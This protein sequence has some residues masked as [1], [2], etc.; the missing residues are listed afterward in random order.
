[1]QNPNPVPIVVLISGNGSN[2]Q[3]IIDAIQTQLLPIRIKAVISSD[4]N[5]YGL[6]RAELA[7]IPQHALSPADYSDRQS[8][9]QALATCIDNYNTELI[10]LAG[11]MR[12]LGNEFLTTFK[13][14]ILN[15]H[16][17]LLPKY[18]GLKT[19]ELA[20]AD[21]ISEHGC[22]VHYVNEAL[23]A[24]PLIAQAV[25]KVTSDE[26][27]ATLKTKVHRAEHFLYPTVLN[28]FANQRVNL[29]NNQVILDNVILP[30]T[31][32]RFVLEG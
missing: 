5:A 29:L 1:M 26:T 25:I 18:P 6:K 31:G 2:L 28:W 13:N 16:P 14:K 24:G 17:S 7:N 3:A 22:S 19:H 23:D 27:V 4:P 30:P 21:K 12:I 9:D 8:Y 15:I 32:L 10:V 20:I 11:F